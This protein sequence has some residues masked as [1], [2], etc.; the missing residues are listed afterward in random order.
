MADFVNFQS[1]SETFVS[2]TQKFLLPHLLRCEKKE[3]GSKSLLLHDLLVEIS[4]S[5]LILPLQIFKNFKDE[6]FGPLF[7]ST[8]EVLTLAL[9]CLYAYP[10]ADQLEIAFQYIDCLPEKNF[11]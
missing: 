5:S 4:T 3:P 10:E 8:E 1:T 11:G 9:D 7:T 6:Q 2:D